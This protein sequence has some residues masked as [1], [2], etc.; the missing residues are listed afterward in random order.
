MQNEFIDQYITTIGVDFSV[1]HTKTVDSFEKKLFL[2]L[3]LWVRAETSNNHTRELVYGFLT[4]ASFLRRIRRVASDLEQSLKLTTVACMASS[5]SSVWRTGNHFI[6]FE[7]G[8]R[9]LSDSRPL[10]PRKR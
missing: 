9:K 8:S 1:R 5:F 3:Q 6:T 7:I 4:D 10:D 2:K